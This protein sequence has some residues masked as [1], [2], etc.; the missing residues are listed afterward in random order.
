MVQVGGLSSSQM[1][2]AGGP[3]GVYMF[4]KFLITGSKP[5]TPYFE[6]KNAL[7][8]ALSQRERELSAF[9]LKGEG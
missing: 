1:S 9:P 5:S 4:L 2:R 3:S 7:N 6:S 8:P